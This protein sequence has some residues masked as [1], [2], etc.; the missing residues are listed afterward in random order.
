MHDRPDLGK[1]AIA[2]SI[3][4]LLSISERR[5]NPL[6]VQAFFDAKSDEV[7]QVFNGGPSFDTQVLVDELNR[8]APFFTAK[9]G[10]IK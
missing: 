2:G 6:L 7:V 3:S 4:S 1:Q 5:S 9:W 10:E 8:V